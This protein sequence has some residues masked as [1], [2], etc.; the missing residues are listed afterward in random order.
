MPKAKQHLKRRRLGRLSPR[1]SV[2]LQCPYCHELVCMTVESDVCGEMIQDCSVCCN[3]W[4]LTV[5][6]PEG[7]LGDEPAVTFG[8]VDIDRL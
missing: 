7:E 2:W 8:H 6:Q 5:T 3:P 4:R 1:G